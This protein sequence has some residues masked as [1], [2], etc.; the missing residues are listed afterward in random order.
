[1]V[2]QKRKWQLDLT[3]DTE[4]GVLCDSLVQQIAPGR[5][6]QPKEAPLQQLTG[7][8]WHEH[9]STAMVGQGMPDAVTSHCT[10]QQ[11]TLDAAV[12]TAAEGSG[13]LQ[14]APASSNTKHLPAHSTHSARTQPAGA[15]LQPPAIHAT[16]HRPPI[17]D[18]GAS[19]RL[20]EESVP[21][22][23]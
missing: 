3:D 8:P 18:Q 21:G 17:A 14:A 15:C 22:A 16:A 7:C 12:V 13:A 2:P 1:M 4:A 5:A 23:R 11:P 9:V 6:T 20:T 19:L 10:G